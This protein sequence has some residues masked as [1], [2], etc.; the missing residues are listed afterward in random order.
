ME[1]L[2]YPSKLYKIRLVKAERDNYGHPILSDEWDKIANLL[3]EDVKHEMFH[4]VHPQINGIVYERNYKR[5]PVSGIAVLEIGKVGYTSDYAKVRLNTKSYMYEEPYLALEG[6]YPAF[7]DPEMLAE[8]IM[9]AFN[10]ALKEYGLEV[11]LEPWESTEP[12]K[13]ILDFELSYEQELKKHP[14]IKKNCIAFQQAVAYKEMVNELGNLGK[15]RGSRNSDKTFRDYI[16]VKNKDA[17]L[18]IAHDFSDKNIRACVVMMVQK[19]MIDANVLSRPPYRV[20]VEEF[21]SGK[22]RSSTSYSELNN[23]N[24]SKFTE[25]PLYLKLLSIFTKI[26]NEKF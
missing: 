15:K 9:R 19:A 8:I 12:I 16:K 18:K 13:W 3:Y 5:C 4:F 26:K 23:P 6:F 21:G 17:V 1:I 14:E 2:N 11:T 20:F 7:N 10:W 25:E 24:D 22:G